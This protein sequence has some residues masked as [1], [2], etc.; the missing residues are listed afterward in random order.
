MQKR[1]VWSTVH[2]I[3]SIFVNM[4]EDNVIFKTCSMYVIQLYQPTKLYLRPKE[5]VLMKC[6][7]LHVGQDGLTLECLGIY[8]GGGRISC[9]LQTSPEVHP[10][11]YAMGTSYSPRIKQLK[12]GVDHQPVSYVS[13]QMGTRCTSTSLYACVGMWWGELYLYNLTHKY[14]PYVITLHLPLALRWQ[15]SC[16]WALLVGIWI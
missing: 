16:S 7:T 1:S 5:I 13:L 10:A 6:T 2:C 15:Y 12:H 4:P 8:C 9:A 3:D 14:L 11:S